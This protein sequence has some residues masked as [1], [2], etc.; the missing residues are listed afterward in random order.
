MKLIDY[1]R[2]RGIHYNTAWRHFKQGK[3]NT[4]VDESG[5]IFVL[6]D[7]IP[8]ETLDDILHEFCRKVKKHFEK[9]GK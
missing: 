3:L 4:E 2:L 1:S 8:E 7:S 5:N 6:D 9:G